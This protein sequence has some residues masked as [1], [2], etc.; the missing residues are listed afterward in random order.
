MGS[1]AATHQGAARY[2]AGIREHCPRVRG[3]GKAGE[4][5]EQDHVDHAEERTSHPRPQHAGGHRKLGEEYE[6][7]SD[8]RA[9][10]AA[11]V[12]VAPHC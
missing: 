10:Q 1:V 5:V 4:Q 11:W 8:H 7:V 12:H 9:H 3:V 2:G 6:G